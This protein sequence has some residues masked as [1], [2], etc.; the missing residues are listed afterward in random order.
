MNILDSISE[1]S[2]WIMYY[3]HKIGKGNISEKDA[4]DLYGFIVDK[5]YLPAVEKI[6]NFE[7][8]PVPKKKLIGKSGVK[9]KRVV[10]TYGREE[11][12]V[13]KLMSFLLRDYDCIFAPNL[14]SFRKN[15]GVKAAINKLLKIR[16]ISSYYTYKVDVSD[17]FN[18]VDIS[19]LLPELRAVLS[20][21]PA[22]FEFIRSLLENPYVE[23]ESG[24]ISEKKGIMAGVPISGFLAN[25]YLSSMDFYF[26]E[27][28]IPYMR[29]SDDIIVF[30]KTKNELDEHIAAIKNM[31]SERRLK[32][33][34]KKETITEPNE[35]WSFLGFSFNGEVVDICPVS[36]EKLK[37]KMRRKT[38][39]LARWASKKGVSGKYAARA[40]VKQFNAKLY[41]NPIY[42]ELTW[43]RWFFPIINT[44][45]TLREIDAY[46]QECIRYLATGKR[47][48]GRFDFRYEEIKELGYKSLVNEYYK[49]K[50]DE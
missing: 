38:R 7:P 25:L 43:T 42:N 30:A 5:E 37:A 50:S 49:Q 26:Y 22:L 6:Q 31:L 11:N 10:Y 18:S 33:N 23:T 3:E 8:F 46:M 35:R 15:S 36:Y 28:G 14:Y 12:Y 27:K 13:L 40:F 45:K 19:I 21:D 1:R 39:A 24:L 17:Y 29:Y 16:D 34:E 4:K 48:K 41:D 32:V 2:Q 47:T 44:D 9:K 20:D